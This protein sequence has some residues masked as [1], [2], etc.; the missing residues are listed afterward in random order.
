MQA[1]PGSPE[2]LGATPPPTPSCA[3]APAAPAH[4][5]HRWNTLSGLP[6][7]SDFTCTISQAVLASASGWNGECGSGAYQRDG[8]AFYKS[9]FQLWRAM[10]ESGAP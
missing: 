3:A 6:S 9:L 4:L 5:Q 10:G 2:G 1:R 7:D 8:R